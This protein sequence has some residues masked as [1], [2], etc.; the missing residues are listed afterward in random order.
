MLI[1]LLAERP[2]LTVPLARIRFA[3][4]GGE[5][6]RERLADWIALAEAESGRETLPA[7]WVAHDDG[8]VLGGMG[9]AVRDPPDRR[10][11]GPWLIGVVVRPEDRRRGVGRALFAAVESWALAG[12]HRELW[13]LTDGRAAV[14]F[15][16]GCG[17][18]VEA[19]GTEVVLRKAPIGH[20]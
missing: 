4:W 15:Y 9:L 8:R 2:E 17:M 11:A 19:A 7:T 1:E 13:V 3:E 5:P 20:Y 6:G 12:G 18:T 10:T 16:R 14:D